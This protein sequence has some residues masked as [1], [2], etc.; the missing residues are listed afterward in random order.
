MDNK[1]K[2]DAFAQNLELAAAY[3][4][5]ALVLHTQ[6]K[7]DEA[8]KNYQ[9]ALALQPNHAD[10]YNNLAC[11]YGKQGKLAAAVE[12]YQKSLLLNPDSATTHNNLGVILKNQGKLEAAIASFQKA[13]TLNPSDASIYYNLAN[14][15][16]IQR[17]FTEAIAN[18]RHALILKPDYHEAYSMLVDSQLNYHDWT[19]YELNLQKMTQ[20]VQERKSGCS[21]PLCFM[22]L[23]DSA[24]QQL[25]CATAYTLTQYPPAAMPLWTGQPY[26][27]K[28]IRIAYISADFRNHP[29]STLMVGIFEQH[30]RERFDITAI[31]LNKAEDSSLGRR[32]KSAFENFIEVFDKSD[33]EIA[34]LIRQ[35]EIDIAIDLT[36]FTK[37]CRPRVFALRPAP[38]QINYLGFP[39]T[40]GANYIDYIFADKFL[41]PEHY[42]HFYAEKI[43]YLP[44]CFQANDDKRAIVTNPP[45]RLDVGLPEMGFVFCTF[46]ISHKITPIFFDGWMRV[47]NQVKDSV[48]WLVCEDVIAQE[49]LRN[50]AISC[51]IYPQRLIF[52][53]RLSDYAEHLARFSLA[54]LFLDTLPFNAGTTASDALWVGVPVLTYTGEAFAARMAGSLLTTIDLPELITHN[55]VDYEKLAIELATNPQKLAQIRTKLAKNRL[56]SP[57]F[58]TQRFCRY[59][60]IAYQTIAANY[61][62]GKAPASFAVQA[63]EQIK[64]PVGVTLTQALSIAQKHLNKGEFS[65]AESIY[66]QIIAKNPNNTEAL[67]WLGVVYHQ[68]GNNSHAIEFIGK[69]AKLNPKNAIYACNLGVVLSADNQINEAIHSYQQALLY[70]SDDVNT[71][72]NLGNAFKKLGQLDAA[73]ESYQRALTIDPNRASGYNNLGEIFREQGKWDAAMACYQKVLAQ[74]PNNFDTL[75]NLSCVFVAQ[76]HEE[77]AETCYQ[78]VLHIKPDHAKAIDALFQIEHYRCDWSKYDVRIKQTIQIVENNE[79][80]YRPFAFLHVSGKA[81][82]QHQNAENYTRLEYP[83]FRP[84]WTGQRYNHAKIRIAYLSGDFCEHAVTYLTVGLFE[85]HDRN[86]FEIFAFSFLPEDKTPTGQRVKAAFDQFIDIS[87][88]NDNEVAQLLFQL[89]IDIAVDLMGFTKN[90]RTHIFAQRPAPIQINYLGFPGTMGASYMDYIFADKFLIPE[91]LKSCYTEQ[92]VYLPECFQ[93]NDNKRFVSTKKTSR[94]EVG[95]PETGFIF[96]SFNGN[97]KITPTF[98]ACWMRLLAKIPD[99]VLWIVCDDLTAKN[100][101]RQSAMNLGVDANRL[102]FAHRM[103]Y[104]D[105]LTRFALADLFLDTLPFNAGTTASDALWAGV[106]VLTCIGEVFAARMA[107]SLLHAIGLPELITDNLHDY[108]EMAFKLATTPELFSEIR[109]KLAKNRTTYPLF[110]TQRFCQHLESAYMTMWERY[111]RCEPP[112]SFTVST[113]NSNQPMLNHD[114]IRQT[115]ETALAHQKAGRLSEAEILYQHVLKSQPNNADAWHFLGLLSHQVGKNDVAE[116]L[117]SK[118]ISFNP[119]SVAY[120]NLGLVLGVQG[121]LE[122]SVK[123]YQTAIALQPN[124]AEA[125]NNLG[126]VYGKQGKLALAIESYQQA[127]VLKPNYSEAHNNLGVTFKNQHKLNEALECFQNALKITQSDASIYYNLGNVLKSQNKLTEAIVSYRRALA[128]KPNY[129]EAQSSLMYLQQHNHDWTDYAANLEKVINAVQEQKFGCTPLSFLRLSDSVRTQ[130]QCATVYAAT[131]NP[132]AIKPL[133]RGECYAHDKIRVAYLSADLGDHPVSILMVGLFEEH[134]KQRFE[135]IALSLQK[136]ADSPLVERVKAAFDQ[137]I[138]V[139]DKS[140]IEIALL[141]QTL[142]V[143]ILVDLMGFTKGCRTSVFGHRPAP[144]QVNYLG[145]PGT[146]GTNYMDYIIADQHIIPPEKQAFYAEKVAYL[147]DTYMPN[148]AKRV[149]AE[150]TSTR[151]EANLPESGFVFC[152]FNDH[153]KITPEI[154]EVWIRLLKHVENSVLWLRTGNAIMKENLRI[155]VKAHGISPERL[156][157]AQKKEKIE[158]HLARHR[159]ADLFLDTLPYNAHATTCDALWAGLPVLTCRGESFASRVAASLLHA[160]GLPELIT[161]NLKDYETLALKLATTP[162]FLAQIQVKLAHNRLT[163]PLFDTKRF[164]RNLEKAY[165]RM[166]EN[167]Q[168]GEMPASFCV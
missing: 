137:F 99:S 124:Y 8:I 30:D 121:K 23:S 97:Y 46:N 90:C 129:H 81:A 21:T 163:M 84:L 142:E 94:A 141:I 17:Q 70:R 91:S 43:I 26:S 79:Q 150:F 20:L 78:K 114:S 105:H 149:I 154:F 39:G 62:A 122:E 32:V 101:L 73:I 36:G 69:A 9:A 19:D 64:P 135:L 34:L 156:V 167:Y 147:P 104:S 108:E 52:A 14:L 31:S 71:L 162:E 92:I 51:G 5:L 58:N 127:I 166:W 50:R 47:L 11:A 37:D 7:L 55:L 131:Q 12:S 61:Q 72:Y 143:D 59:L 113:Q 132:S 86:R 120:S 2:S 29:V 123:N 41:I 38:I 145:F 155:I 83:T 161:D 53:Q 126:S 68:M 168:R 48:L 42:Q 165:T 160:V 57:L 85:Q 125:Y 10:A 128:L 40:M 89:E 159:L 27:H 157:F 15:L 144:I 45:N 117:I 151:A 63:T 67:H 153:Y 164:S 88:K 107:G 148:D 93:A 80:S 4:K 65:Q 116:Q 146:M 49:N 118:A 98:F 96:C 60:E 22:S 35:L 16:K 13:L 115:L 87:Q 66:Q 140:D 44:D 119:N 134:D 133:W 77:Q 130:L 111:Q 112:A 54:D 25:Q 152:C 76:G 106:P 138:D 6:G 139:A 158:D 102:F 18:Y 95:L 82:L 3:F 75:F 1:N 24:N 110:N 100:N 74:Q 56:T 33:T 109:L 103:A 28:K 136:S